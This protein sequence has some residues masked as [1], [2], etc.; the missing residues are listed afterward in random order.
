ME[1]LYLNFASVNQDLVLFANKDGVHWYKL[2]ENILI[3]TN[4]SVVNSE[5]VKKI[6]QFIQ[7]N[8]QMIFAVD[9]MRRYLYRFNANSGKFATIFSPPKFQ[10]VSA[11]IAL[12][13][14]TLSSGFNTTDRWNSLAPAPRGA[15]DRGQIFLF[16]DYTRTLAIVHLDQV[17]LFYQKIQVQYEEVRTA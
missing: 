2:I 4:A 7:S 3:P 5:E 13:S 15:M 14:L 8:S 6:A 9:S 12:W 1:N 11:D 17:F 16:L 10:F